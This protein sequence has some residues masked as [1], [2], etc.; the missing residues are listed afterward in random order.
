MG[1]IEYANHLRNN[2]LDSISLQVDKL[3]FPRAMQF[4]EQEF[5]RSTKLERGENA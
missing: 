4:W 5:S 2:L 1:N 3:N